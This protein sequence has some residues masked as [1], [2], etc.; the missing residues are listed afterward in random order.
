MN[1]PVILILWCILFLMS[2]PLA[3]LALVMWPFIWLL[4]LPFRLVGVACGALFALLKGLLYLP[5]RILGWR[6]SSAKQA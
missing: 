2:W 5:A 1:T 4:S 6:P 3:I